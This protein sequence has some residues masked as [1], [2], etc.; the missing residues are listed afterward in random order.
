M[1]PLAS[2]ITLLVQLLIAGLLVYGVYWFVGMLA[3]PPPIKTIVM[4]IVGI[5]GLLYL[6]R[7]FGI[8]V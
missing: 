1:L 6:L 8:A 5:V 7:L 2:P 3:L 4:V